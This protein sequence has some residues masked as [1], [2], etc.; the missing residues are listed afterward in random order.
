MDPDPEILFRIHQ[1]MK[2][3]IKKCNFSLSYCPTY[4]PTV[5]VTRGKGEQDI[6]LLCSLFR[7]CFV[8]ITVVTEDEK[9]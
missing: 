7:E 8:E 6:M 3:L 2:E 9:R 4:C 1:N 5:A